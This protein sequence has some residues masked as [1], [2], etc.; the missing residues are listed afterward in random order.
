M[1]ELIQAAD[2]GGIEAGRFDGAILAGSVHAG[3]IQDSLT[4]FVRANADALAALRTLYLQV[5][6]A[7]AGTDVQDRADLDRV[8]AR[9]AEETGL[10]PGRTEHVAGAFHFGEYDFFKTWAMRWIAHRKGEEIP[11]GGDRE[12]TD[13]PA[14]GAVLDGWAS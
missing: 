1:V 5:S 9:F 14:L 3:L 10:A 7:A 12:Y 8:A 11:R 6:L 2:A 13:W 4:A